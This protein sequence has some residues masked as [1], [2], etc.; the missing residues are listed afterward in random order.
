MAIVQKFGK[1]D[2]FLTMTC[3]PSWEEIKRELLPG[4]T[5]QDRPDLLTRIFRAKCEELK[6]DIFHRGILGK[7]VAHVH[8]IEFQKRG[9]PHVHM[10]VIFDEDD[11]LNNP[12]DYYCIV[13][14]EIPKQNEEPEL[15]AAV[16]KHM[17]HG[18]CGHIKPNAPC[19]KNGRCKKGYPKQF[20]ECFMQG[21]DSYPIYQRRNDNRSIALDNDGEVVVDN[22]WVVPYNS[23]LLLKYD[24]HINVEVCSSIK[25]V[26]YMY[27]YVYK[28]PDC[29]VFE[30]R[31]GPNYDEINQ[32]VDGRWIC[33]PE[34]LWRIFKFSMSRI[35]PSVIRLQI[36]LPNRQQVQFYSYQ[37]ISDVLADERNSRTMLT[38]FFKIYSEGQEPNKYLY[39]DFPNYYR[40]F[41]S[42]RIWVKRRTTQKV[43]G[44]VY[45]VSPNEGERFYLRVMPNH[46]KGPKSFDDLLTV[47]GVHYLTFK[48][49]AEKRGLLQEDNSIRECLVETRSFRTPSA[50]RRLFATI[51]LY[52]EPS[53]VRNLWEENYSY[54]IEDYPSS[55]SS[56]SLFVLN[57]LL[58]DLN[59]ILMQHKRSINEFDL[60]QITEGF[61]DLTNI[62]GLIEDELSIPIS[63]TDLNA[64]RLLNGCQLSAFDVISQ[65]IRRKHSTIFFVDGP[66]GTGKT[67]LYKSL[68][69]TFRKD[70]LIMLAIA[71]SSIAANLLPGG[72]TAHSKL[73][74]QIKFEPLSMCRFS[75]QSELST[76]IERISAIIWDEAPMANRKAFETLD[77]TFRDILG[78]DLPFGGKVMILGGDFR[79]VLPVVISG[80]KSQI[81]N[82]SIVQ[83]PLWS[84]VKVLHLSEN[85]RA[86]NDEVFSDFFASY[87][88]R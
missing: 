60:P 26:K 13:R 14:A 6:E 57:K 50:L 78:V 19:M 15:Y 49:A 34:A 73:K 29:V 20:V 87:W 59:G 1:S 85:M 7:V 75:K 48:Q 70:G 18:P 77:R 4:Q 86:Q 81:I 55:S 41:S 30:I 56:S 69:A 71:T 36:H 68:L 51:L 76:L 31:P 64:V 46:I 8:V 16:I 32:Y 23:W 52:C 58:H 38:E 17:I 27:K 12:D 79:Q 33:A 67:F 37:S 83:S 88:K 2:I 63:E 80:T 28:G 47:D 45:A 10:L 62:S 72:R 25:S 42:Q 65:A 35:Y 21:N 44:R 43:I 3:N 39:K 53:G 22:S 74:I 54:M 61:E 40:W 24:C 82:A 84:N 11:K 66:G 9:L 5:T